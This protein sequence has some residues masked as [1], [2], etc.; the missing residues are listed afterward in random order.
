M[1]VL[2]IG[3]KVAHEGHSPVVRAVTL[4]N[5]KYLHSAIPGGLAV[6]N[7]SAVQEM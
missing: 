2:E 7:L 5:R 6:K 1:K 3:W 4:R